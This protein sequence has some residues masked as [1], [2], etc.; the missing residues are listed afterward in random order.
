MLL[1]LVIRD[2]DPIFDAFKTVLDYSGHSKAIG[3]ALIVEE[4]E[5]PADGN[6]DEARSL[7]S[8]SSD[9]GNED[10]HERKATAEQ[11][12]ATLSD[13][14]IDM[15]KE[16]LAEAADMDGATLSW[17]VSIL[18]KKEFELT[19]ASTALKTLKK[20]FLAH[21]KQAQDDSQCSLRRSC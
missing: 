17:M 20:D 2:D 7:G 12:V 8:N 1:L 15:D 18:K 13:A 3:S 9:E 21:P 11:W 10:D 4:E 19:T 16:F 5:L 14:S 6:E